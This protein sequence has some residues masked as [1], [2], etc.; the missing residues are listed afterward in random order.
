VIIIICIAV[1]LFSI[2]I[3]ASAANARESIS[4]EEYRK[5]GG[6]SYVKLSDGWTNYEL[7]GDTNAT[8]TV[9]LIHGGTIP[10]CIW[11][12]Q[13][14]ALKSA[15]V[16]ILRY[17]QYGRGFSD[18][19]DSIYSRELFCRQLKELL[20]ALKI[21][22]P[23]D[24]IGPSFGGAIAITI[25]SKYPERV[26]SIL[27]I[28][29]ALNVINSDSPLSGPIKLMRTPVFGKLAYKLIIK[30]KLI[31]R[32]GLMIPGGK[33]SPC[34]TT[35]AYQFKCKGTDRSLLS[36]FKS[37]A[38]GDYRSL[39]KI[40]GKQHKKMLL[41]R[42]KADKEITPLMINE[43]R[44]DLP[45]CPFMELES[46]GHSPGTDSADKLNKIIVDFVLGE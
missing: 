45:E 15:G 27:L 28:S 23:V 26:R 38:F 33:T 31:A 22:T 46:S 13:M 18:R 7:S 30:R 3:I 34:A 9:V 11:E 4:Y 10:L 43:I 2:G 1:A 8:H 21:T 32:A 39:T 14:D 42:G 12:P 17:D 40:S 37:D 35:F 36:M 19:P 20:D 44:E 24:I 41:L 16:K 29:P 5:K 25:N 6:N